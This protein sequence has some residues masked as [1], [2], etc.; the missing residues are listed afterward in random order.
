MMNIPQIDSHLPYQEMEGRVVKSHLSSSHQQK[1]LL[2]N[3]IHK[4][5][6]FKTHSLKECMIHYSKKLM[7]LM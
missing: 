4:E 6:N 2:V 3:V 7:Y 5:S 1:I